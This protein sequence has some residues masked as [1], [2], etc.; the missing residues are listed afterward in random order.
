M[1][2]EK[3]EYNIEVIILKKEDKCFIGTKQAMN[4][5]S[6]LYVFGDNL[7]RKGFAGQAAVF[8]GLQNSFG[9]CTKIKPSNDHD[10]FFND[11][12]YKENI[13]HIHQDFVHL[14]SEIANNS[15]QKIVFL[16]LGEGLAKLKEKAPYTYE[17]LQKCIEKAKFYLE[18]ND[19]SFYEKSLFKNTISAWLTS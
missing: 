14:M 10:A 6:T 11:T 17:Y 13:S 15:D 2:Q 1:E 3:N 5:T 12:K 8:R 16:P 19:I 9:I 4:D 7:A 18:N